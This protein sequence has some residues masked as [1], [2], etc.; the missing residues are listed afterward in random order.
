MEFGPEK[1]QQRSIKL[2]LD[3]LGMIDNRERG[4]RGNRER[5]NFACLGREG[6]NLYTLHTVQHL[7]LSLL[8]LPSLSPLSPLSHAHARQRRKDVNGKTFRE[9]CT[10]ISRV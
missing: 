4:K 10:G 5:G 3:G 8:S 1:Q 7:S 6:P 9:L 2:G